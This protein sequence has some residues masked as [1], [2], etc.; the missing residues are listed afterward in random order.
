MI[1]QVGLFPHRTVSANVATVPQLL[2]WDRDR[3]KARVSEL[4]D[5]VGLGESMAR[6][7]QELRAE[8]GLEDTAEIDDDSESTPPQR[9][10]R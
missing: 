4:L 8:M 10:A 7:K 5:L 2:G 9:V 6:R 1:Q 3:T